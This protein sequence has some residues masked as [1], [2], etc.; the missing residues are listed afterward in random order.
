[1][2]GEAKKTLG[3]LPYRVDFSNNE[4]CS[5]GSWTNPKYRR[6]GISNY[7]NF[8]AFQFLN[9]RGKVIERSSIPKSNISSQKSRQPNPPKIYAEAR[10]LKILCWKWW[11]EKPLP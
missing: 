10:Y 3:E 9:E 8:K 11:K 1:M 4:A 6:M 5:G 2:T 7:D